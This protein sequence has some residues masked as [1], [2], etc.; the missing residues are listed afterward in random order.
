[1]GTHAALAAGK[2]AVI[3]GAASG[4][5]L[6]AA[7]RF[8]GLG[9]QVLM[10]DVDRGPLEAAA[11]EVRPLAQQH[12]AKVV[13]RPVDVSQFAEV[14]ALKDAAYAA[15]GRVDVLMNNAGTSRTT[16]S[17]EAL[18]DWRRI[19]EVN[20]W[21]VIHG[22]HA[23]AQAMIDQQA[24]ALIVNTGS[25]QG[26]TNPPGNPAYNV[27]KAGVKAATE[28]LQH[29]LR[30]TPGCQVSAHLLVPG[31]T[32]TGMTRQHAAEKPAG[33]WLPEQVVDTMIEAVGR[34]SFY[35]ICPDNEVTPAEDARRILWAAGDLV[36]GRPALSRWHP[37]YREAFQQFAP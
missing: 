36:H 10:A 8:A 34:G 20:L 3:T 22:V 30:N 14:A 9:M 18:E 21:G 5:G 2:A 26:I 28:A 12:G 33:A 24:P 23:F 17:W 27:S 25:K 31:Y 1:M 4:I 13:A 32:Y 15:F 6:A 19:V 37:D 35:I 29:A 16:G 11:A 7:K